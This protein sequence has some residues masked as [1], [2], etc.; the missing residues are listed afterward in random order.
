[1]VMVERPF[2][3]PS[4]NV[5]SQQL[6]TFRP[7][8]TS[9][10]EAGKDPYK[11]WLPGDLPAKRHYRPMVIMFIGRRGRG[12]TTCMTCFA[13]LL[14]KRRL[15]AGY[16]AWAEVL[17]NYWTDFSKPDPYLLDKLIEFPEGLHHKIILV[18]EA[19]TALANRRSLMTINLLI[20]NMLM[21]LRK[22]K[23]DMLFTTQ[24]PQ[25]IDF[26]VLYQVDLF[27]ECDMDPAGN[28]ADLYIHDHWGQ[29]TGMDYRKPWP[30]R[31]WMADKKIQ[32]FYPKSM[33]GRFNSDEVVAPVY[34]KNRDEVIAQQWALPS[35]QEADEETGL[36]AKAPATMEEFVATLSGPFNPT[37][38][39]HIAKKFDPNIKSKWDFVRALETM[40]WK[41]VGEG[42]DIQME[43]A[44]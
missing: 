9:V 23:L 34:L 27:I 2:T 20:S 25:F 39:L 3:L 42:Q 35:G 8:V 14:R 26:Q 28:M 21:Q 5:L 12:K 29:W 13:L 43:R 36:P 40:G 44:S 22:R 1:M 4:A 11:L 15:A 32:L 17:S 16:V 18:D 33:F 19:M 41:R 30:P 31:R 38:F 6:A 24:F 10:G 7:H 37:A